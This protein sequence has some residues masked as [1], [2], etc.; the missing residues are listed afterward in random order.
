MN[1]DE[2]VEK[3]FHQLYGMICEA[4]TWSSRGKEDDLSRRMSKNAEAL[5]LLLRK[6]Y[7]EMNKTKPPSVSPPGKPPVR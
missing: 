5:K 1:Q 6:T 4:L 2:F 3:Y 7:E